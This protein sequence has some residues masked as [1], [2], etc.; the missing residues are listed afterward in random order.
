MKSFLET[1]EVQDKINELLLLHKQFV[2]DNMQEV[3][4]LVSDQKSRF[5]KVRCWL[6]YGHLNKKGIC[7]RCG[8]V[9]NNSNQG[10]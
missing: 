7:V 5:F 9:L 6:V 10:K 4:P 3:D 1:T 2:M 8:K